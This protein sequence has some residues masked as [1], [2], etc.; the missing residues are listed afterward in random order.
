MAG[1]G[2][3][4]TLADLLK[5]AALPGG[6]PRVPGPVG[7][8]G[9]EIIMPEG[10]PGGPQSPWDN[11]GRTA[12][13]GIE[14]L[15]GSAGM[16]A[17]APGAIANTLSSVM[18]YAP[19][20][21]ATLAGFLGLTAPSQAGP[22]AD[23]SVKE[24]VVP[25]GVADEN[26]LKEL[27]GQRK[28]LDE[29]R[30]TA[31]RER[32]AQ[33]QGKDG[34]NA[35]RGPVYTAKEAEVGRLT[36]EMTRLDTA[37]AG[38][39][40]RLDPE[41]QAQIAK[42]SDAEATRRQML[43]EA[44]KP[45]DREYPTWQKLQTVMPA[46]VAAGTATIPAIADVVG[47]RFG[48]KGWRNAIK[49]G[50]R[51]GATHADQK[52]ASDIAQKYAKDQFPEKKSELSKYLIMGGIGGLEGAGV[53]NYPQ[54][55]NSNLPAVN[56]ERAAYEEFIKRLPAGEVGDAERK[57]AEDIIGSLPKK[58]QEREAAL[59]YFGSPMTVGLRTGLGALEGVGGAIGM[60][61]LLRSG[62]PSEANMPRPQTDALE[63]MVKRNETAG[64][65][66]AT[67]AALSKLPHYEFQPR[68]GGQFAGPPQ[69][70]PGHPLHQ[71]KKP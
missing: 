23:K 26:F 66:P 38:I 70:P 16:S 55:Y 62:M 32:D 61:K 22:G 50:F 11:P 44:P 25:T 71:P 19:K 24:S 2:D 20:T 13:A 43:N 68:K 39:Q 36:T 69:Y 60:S 30:A 54:Y 58:T 9:Q 7:P 10:T 48:V 37:I 52:V 40:K 51:P 65:D 18:G 59:E 42:L 56:P 17:G 46:L 64:P 5:G 53:A 41:Y 33:L 67:A 27:V 31:V 29:Q 6:R 21:M 1:P 34:R 15:A 14:G 3:A 47:A 4:A 45:F 28:S 49:D 35:G 12:M 57:K 8:D 63:K